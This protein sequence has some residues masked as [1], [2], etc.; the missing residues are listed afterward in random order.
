MFGDVNPPHVLLAQFYAASQA[1]GESMTD[2]Y[3]RLEDLASRITRKDTNVISP[4][5]YNILINTQFWTKLYSEKIKDALR[6]KFDQLANSPQFIIE[7]RKV[8]SECNTKEVKV[9]QLNSDI[10]ATIQ[11]GF[12]RLNSRL[13]ELE[14]KVHS[15][16]TGTGSHHNPPHR[17]KP[18]TDSDKG[19]KKSIICFKCREP[20]HIA[21][22]CHLNAQGSVKESGLTSH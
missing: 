13:N 21:K 3:S 11:Q 5:N 8:E 16:A 19:Q 2:W 9:N 12:E 4:N 6:H 1:P 18:R 15:Q 7:A 10:S 22:K 14:R 20:G 17:S